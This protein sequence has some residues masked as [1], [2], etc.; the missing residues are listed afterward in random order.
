MGLADVQPELRGEVNLNDWIYIRLPFDKE[1]KAGFID[2]TRGGTANCFCG[3]NEFCTHAEIA[4]TKSNLDLY[5]YFSYPDCSSEDEFCTTIPLL[6]S[7]GIGVDLNV[8][9][10]N[11]VEAFRVYFRTSDFINILEGLGNDT[12]I[13]LISRGDSVIS[14]RKSVIEWIETLR[15]PNICT[16]KSHGV[17]SEMSLKQNA[18]NRTFKAADRI[19]RITRNRCLPCH[20]AIT[21]AEK[22]DY[23]DYATGEPVRWKNPSGFRDAVIE[24]RKRST[25]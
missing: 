9:R 6:P 11:G 14:L 21:L 23:V 18:S 1:A 24:L 19:T 22:V 2:L 16:S 13:T 20:R 3:S 4:V 10:I 25:K 17:K 15:E 12:Y 5:E 7:Y 8:M